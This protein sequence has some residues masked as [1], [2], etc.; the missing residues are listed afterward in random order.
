MIFTGRTS[1]ITTNAT[2]YHS[3]SL[4]HTTRAA[5]RPTSSVLKHTTI[6][7]THPTT[8]PTRHTRLPHLT[9]AST[10]AATGHVSNPVSTRAATTLPSTSAHSGHSHA[11][12]GA[13]LVS[14][15]QKTNSPAPSLS[16]QAVTELSNA[17]T[18]P[19]LTWARTAPTTSSSQ[20]A[21]TRT[22]ELTNSI[23][24]SSE[25]T[26]LNVFGELREN[27]SDEFAN[28][29]NTSLT[30]MFGAWNATAGQKDF[31][32]WN[33]EAEST[34]DPSISRAIAVVLWSVLGPCVVFFV[35]IAGVLVA[36]ILS[37]LC[38]PRQSTL[39]TPNTRSGP[40]ESAASADVPARASVIAFDSRTGAPVLLMIESS[41]AVLNS[42][43]STFPVSA[44]P[45]ALPPSYSAA[46]QPQYAQRSN[47]TGDIVIM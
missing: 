21:L 25:W 41:H 46:V 43:L 40:L 38:C 15:R 8:G 12:S 34:Q 10:P 28:D 37:K 24:E 39:N 26:T 13:T 29:S 35:L 45:L 33:G 11:H 31:L 18:A 32:L 23:Q 30:T 44:P 2:L 17:S 7:I 6:G 3:S 36:A 14:R 5:T 22:L 20:T 27:T 16:T 47:R 42:Q 9:L 19:I 1:R 4:N